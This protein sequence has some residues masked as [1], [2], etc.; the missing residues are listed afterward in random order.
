MSI[1]TQQLTTTTVGDS[2]RKLTSLWPGQSVAVQSTTC[3]V[4]EL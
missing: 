3:A 2:I 1:E 4:C